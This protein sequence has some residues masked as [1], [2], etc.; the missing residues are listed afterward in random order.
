ML[1]SDL[2]S[3]KDIL[4]KD[5]ISACFNS[6]EHE[7]D[8]GSVLV[9]IAILDEMLTLQLKKKFHNGNYETR[10][11]LFNPPRGSISEFSAKV[12]I[13]F[14]LD[15]IPQH[16]HCDIRLLNKLRNKCAH[17]WDKFHFTDEV[18]NEYIE[19]M[20][21]YKVLRSQENR[22]V[23]WHSEELDQQVEITDWAPIR[24]K[25]PREIFDWVM[26]I[27]I[28]LMNLYLSAEEDSLS[29]SED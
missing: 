17:N 25:E 13:A 26:A 8:R 7:S 16:I 28:S 24:D 9:S 14:C 23:N 11:R 6:L 3:N 12:D 22:T 1:N 15:V 4:S 18:I 2:T 29:V 21:F 10:K 19:P 20:G 27:T 5:A